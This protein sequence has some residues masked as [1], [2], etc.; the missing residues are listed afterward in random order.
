V[1]RG[2]LRV[3]YVCDF[4]SVHART[5]VEHFA[6]CSAEYEVV[7]VST[8]SAMPMAG[9]ELLQLADEADGRA[10]RRGWAGHLAY[11][12]SL[13]FPSLYARLRGRE[14]LRQGHQQ[15]ERLPGLAGAIDPDVIHVLRTQ[16]EGLVALP[17]RE[18][19]PR[20]PFLL[21]TWGQDL[22]VWARSSRAL[23]RATRRVVANTVHA[24]PDNERDARLLCREYGLS[25]GA[26]TVM[27]ATGGLA[28]ESLE[29]AER[30]ATRRLRGE[31]TLLSMRGYE[32]AYIRIRVLLEALREFLRRHPSAHLYLD[33][34]RGHP[35]KAAVERWLRRYSLAEN[36][37][38]VHLDRRELFE[39][40]RS[41]DLYVSATISDGLPMSLL[42]ALYFGQVPVVSNLESIRPPL[43]PGINGVVFETL[44]P[45][46]IA[47]AWEH[48][49]RLLPARIER[50]HNNRA[51]MAMHFDRLTNI[52]R[53]ASVYHTVA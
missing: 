42:E 17:L 3:L 12:V 22:V 1:A 33:G 19:Y 36:V 28:L 44:T 18:L 15:G 14:L 37:T 45:E 13:S 27:P 4:S 43:V 50:Q 34:P 30:T 38:L 49:L 10:L 39:H 51:M 9:V 40:M 53:I 29:G 23:N 48:A 11:Q 31:P 25:P 41:C 6:A 7:V 21:S 5:L 52:E 20:V 16:P 2:R 8:T 26:Y 24:F 32:N 35:G 47:E 46:A